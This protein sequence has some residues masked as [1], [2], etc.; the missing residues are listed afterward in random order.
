M[1]EFFL[2][3]M[4]FSVVCLTGCD[5]GGGGKN[6]ED[7]SVSLMDGSI[8]IN[9]H[10][11]VRITVMD[12]F[13]EGTAT[14][15]A[16]SVSRKGMTVKATDEE[17][18]GVELRGNDYRF[19]LV[20]QMSTLKID[21]VEVQATHVKITDDGY[22][23]VSYN[24]KGVAHRGGVVVYKFTIHEGTLET[25]KVD[26][27]AVSSMEMSK[28]ELSAIDYHNG[29][30]YVTGAN[31]EPNFG[32]IE[33]RD[34][35]NYAFFMVMEM[36]ANKTFKPT[37]PTVVQLTSFQ[38]T[39][40]RA[41]NDRIY[42]TTGDGTNETDGGL[43]I[44][45][46]TDFELVNFISGKENTRSVDV[47]ANHI[48]LMQAEPARITM[49]DTEGRNETPIYET[50][51]ESMQHHAKSEILAWDKYLFVAENES[52]LR[53][54]FKN[55]DVNDSLDRPGDDPDTDVTNSVCMNS[56]PKKDNKGKTVQSNLLFLANGEKG[57]SW[58]DVMKDGDYER[59]IPCKDN[60]I[61]GGVNVSAN[62]IASKG[63][64]VFV[65]D[66]LGG[67]KALYIGFNVGD[68]PPPVSVACDKFM[69]YLYSG[70]DALLPECKSVFRSNAH[71]VIKKLFTNPD[72]VPNYIEILNSTDLYISYMFEGAGWH[73]SLGYFVIPASVDKTTAAEYTYYNTTVK[74]N[75]YN[76]VRGLYTLKDEYII[77]KNIADAKR[78]GSLIAPNTYRIGN[79]KFNAGERVV[80][81]MVPDGWSSQNN[82]VVLSFGGWN[83]IFFTHKGINLATGVPYGK[84]FGNFKGIQYNTFYAADCNSMVLFFE[85]NHNEGSDIDFNDII[86]SVSDNI[87]ANEIT[88]F[89]LPKNVVVMVDGKPEIK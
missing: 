80:L 36:E 85:D 64:I 73:N 78:G 41:M 59:I 51:D 69:P 60:S 87:E 48:Y 81:F 21:G 47:D 26:I 75:M 8:I 83:Q 23:L 28:A 16:I 86:F 24:D 11:E 65:A 33:D 61:L 20:A 15:P 13:P 31:S 67:L 37:D 72:D 32:Y 54:L 9:N 22:A 57:I 66:G 77:F 1:R 68:E 88:N 18:S 84:A 10:P 3:L 70:V 40:I 89:V 74:P 79:R 63:N 19:K 82:H 39:S 35:F 56:D 45:N 30:L 5:K 12:E 52:G 76:I 55:G 46:A 43:Y 25:V 7:E 2:V 44:Y 62:F 50:T 27:E 34:G 49:Y 42:I 38:G 71:N 17:D 29:K 53:M 14:Q 6:I 58:Y 4:I